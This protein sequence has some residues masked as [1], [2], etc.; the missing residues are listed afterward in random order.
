MGADRPPCTGRSGPCRAPPVR[1][2]IGWTTTRRGV[3]V[4]AGRGFRGSP[5]RQAGRAQRRQALED[6]GDTDAPPR[7]SSRC[8]HRGAPLGPG[9]VRLHRRRRPPL[10]GREP[11]RA[12]LDRVWR[13]HVLSPLHAQARGRA[14]LRRVH[15]HGLLHQRR[16][17]ASWP[18]S[19]TSWASSPRRPRPTARSR[20]SRRA[21]WVPAAWRPPRSS[22]ARWTAG[23]TP[24]AS[25]SG[26]RRYERP[27]PTRGP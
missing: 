3:T 7:Q 2:T 18:A 25:S 5:A 4:P 11:R 10:R 16:G 24:P 19:A 26:W 1:H 20:C 17:R 14:H 15:R 13:G 8:A 23:S 22:T 21:V 12:A 9:G 6:R 27:E